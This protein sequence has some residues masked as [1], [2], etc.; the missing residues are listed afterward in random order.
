MIS[1]LV[2]LLERDN[3]KLSEREMNMKKALNRFAIP[4]NGNDKDEKAA[5]D[6]GIDEKIKMRSTIHLELPYRYADLFNV[7]SGKDSIKL[8]TSKS[9][10]NVVL[11][12]TREKE[13]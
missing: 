12:V 7:F 6:S 3:S 9:R 13:T 1:Y 11:S 5:R 2:H 8:F 4:Y 10:D